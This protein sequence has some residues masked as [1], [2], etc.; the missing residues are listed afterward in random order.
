M[1]D[2][3]FAA[4][5]HTKERTI[6]VTFVDDAL[7]QIQNDS[8]Q[9]SPDSIFLLPP[10]PEA[11][12][13]TSNNH[14]TNKMSRR[15][16][17]GAPPSSNGG[18]NNKWTASSSSSSYHNSARGRGRGQGRGR[19]FG[20]G[21]RFSNHSFVRNEAPTASNKWVRPTNTAAQ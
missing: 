9:R 20:R 3:S 4:L 13:S 6:G 14:N 7:I 1:Q 18:G 12:T 8:I 16:V 21:G 15:F 2:G 17:R 11:P 10:P 5:I 19:S